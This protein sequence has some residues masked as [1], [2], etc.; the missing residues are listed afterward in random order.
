MKQYPSI[1]TKFSKSKVYAFD[2]ID[3]SNIRA[4]WSDKNGFYKFGSRNQIMDENHPYLGDAVGLIRQKEEELSKIFLSQNW[5]RVVAFF[6][7]YGENSFAGS[8]Q[9]EEH[10]VTL[11]DVNVYKRGML[12]PD[13]FIELFESVGIPQVV[14]KGVIDEE[15]VTSVKKG[16]LEGMTFE[17]VVCKYTLKG[18]HKMFK[19]KNRAWIDKLKEKCDG[20]DAL[21]RRLV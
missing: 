12:E 21:F 16:T 11:I 19:I 15:F 7:F 20:N 14:Y 4:E 9:A 6:E 18:E 17:G 8:H 2:K 13:R 5:K 10:F 1:T 3:G